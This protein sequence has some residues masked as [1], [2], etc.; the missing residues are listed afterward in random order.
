M[1]QPSFSALT[2]LACFTVILMGSGAQQDTFDKISVRE[3]ELV[4]DQGKQ[5]VS[6]K[7][8][9]EG[10]VV[11]R[12]R[13]KNET[14]RIKIGADEEGSGFVLLDENTNPGIHAL[15]KKDG[16]SFTVMDKDGR[17]RRY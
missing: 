5:R 9:S 14:I 6:I 17:K 1:K 16:T 11:F 10:E 4:D 13:D 8:E 15:V 7:V 12:L 3:F 2:L